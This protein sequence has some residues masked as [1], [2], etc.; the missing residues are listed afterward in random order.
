MVVLFAIFSLTIST[1]VFAKELLNVTKADG[2]VNIAFF[3]F[4]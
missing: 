1:I 4:L 2:F 3:F